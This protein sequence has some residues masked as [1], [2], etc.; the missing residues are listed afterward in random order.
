MQFSFEGPA[1]ERRKPLSVF[2][3]LIVQ[4][5]ASGGPRSG[6]LY[7]RRRPARLRQRPDA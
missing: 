2:T 3:G 6:R 7:R 5:L 1:G 4:G